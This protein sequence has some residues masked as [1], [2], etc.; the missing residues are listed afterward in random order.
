MQSFLTAVDSSPKKN[1]KEDVECA[2]LKET[3][4]TL[5]AT[6]AP[7]RDFCAQAA[8]NINLPTTLLDFD[9]VLR[10]S[11]IDNTSSLAFTCSQLKALYK[12]CTRLRRSIDIDSR[13]AGRE[14][15]RNNTRKETSIAQKQQ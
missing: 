1:R 5:V 10:L 7:N 14:E 9:R 3:V 4:R 15:S 11:A 13:P 12:E 2:K 6:L 8:L